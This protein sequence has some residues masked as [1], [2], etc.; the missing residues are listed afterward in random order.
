MPDNTLKMSWLLFAYPVVGI[1]IK[2][3]EEH[4]SDGANCS[5]SW[6]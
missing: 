6:L 2:Y 4:C 3:Q 1:C 5:L